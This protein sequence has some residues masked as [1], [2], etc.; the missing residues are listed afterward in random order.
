MVFPSCPHTHLTLYPAGVSWPP[1]TSLPCTAHRFVHKSPPPLPQGSPEQACFSIY[2]QGKG[3][4]EQAALSSHLCASMCSALATCGQ[5][6]SAGGA[7]Q[8]DT[9]HGEQKNP[10]GWHPTM[11]AW[12]VHIGQGHAKKQPKWVNSRQNVFQY[13]A[14]QVKRK[15]GER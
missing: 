2:H 9:A 1:G 4:G 15:S 7:Y 13:P 8:S 14:W 5:R 3:Q 6:H 10:D 12:R 11:E